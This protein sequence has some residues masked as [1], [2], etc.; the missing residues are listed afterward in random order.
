MN[1]IAQTIAK[2]LSV[3]TH[4]IEAAMALL[5]EGATVPFI[6]RYRKEATETLTDVQLRHLEERLYY[7]RELEERRTTILNHIRDQDKLTEELETTIKSAA[8]KARLEDLYL[9]YKPKRRTKA[10]LAKEAGLEPLAWALLQD[11]TLIPEQTAL[12]YINTDK[13]INDASIALEGAKQILMERFAE[14]SELSGLLRESLWEQAILHSKVTSDEKAKSG[15]KFSDYFEFSQPM[16]NIP[17]HRTLALFR[18]RKE[19]V[20]A[21]SIK[22]GTDEQ[23][24]VVLRNSI[25]EKF[26][27]TDQG[28][29]ADAWLLDVVRLTWRL[30]FFPRFELELMARLKESGEDEAIK[31]FSRNMKDLLL[32]SP[33]GCLPIMGLDPG[34]RTGVKIAV[35]DATGKVKATGTIYPHAPQ[36][37]W[38]EAITELA[39]LAEQHAVKLISVGNGT[40]SRETERL[41]RELGK[42]HPELGLKAVT[43]NESGASVYSASKLATQEF[44]DIDVTLRGAIS[45]ARRLQDPLAELVKIDPKAIGVGQ[46]QHDVNQTRLARTL[47]HVVED[48]VNAVG[49]D[50]NTASVPLLTRVSGLSSNLATNITAYRDT[51]GAF[52]NRESLKQVP[53][54]GDKT[55]QQAVGFLRIIDGD[56]PLDAS[57]V[58]PESYSI[59]ERI[60]EAYQRPLN[61]ILGDSAFLNQ[62]DPAQFTDDTFGL[63]TILDVLSELEKPGRD[64]RPEF[65]TANFLEG[66]EDITD[67]ELGM[68]LEGVVTNVTN[69]GVF[70]DIGVHQDGLVHISAMSRD[71]V[72]DPRD[73]VK[74]GTLIKVKIMEVDLERQ[75]IALTMRIA[76]EYTKRTD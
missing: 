54:L 60:T 27:I 69:F 11:P 33:A 1:P 61:S 44:P 5:D 25:A 32:A 48:C 75:R 30:K 64:P 42:Q 21:L 55:F 51:H 41:V 65:K 28:R 16:R 35:I 23:A 39:T 52:P 18:G 6:A 37:K 45:I 38:T 73:L 22:A 29:A 40:A 15:N 3:H 47:D 46:Y 36:S 24:E 13:N 17:P 9:P 43:V 68:I 7:L 34:L 57:A 49:V 74:P 8:T 50:L 59:V 53:R 62:I 67:L 2:E 19:K 12:A 76:A 4:Q 26:N 14:D 31:V 56:N 20:L 58:H 10:Q 70:V 63:P 66:V 71:F 72:K